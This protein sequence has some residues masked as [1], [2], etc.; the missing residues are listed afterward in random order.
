MDPSRKTCSSVV[1]SSVATVIPEPVK[2]FSKKHL[3]PVCQKVAV[4]TRQYILPSTASY[5]KTKVLPFSDPPGWAGKKALNDREIEHL[6]AVISYSQKQLESLD[7]HSE[8]NIVPIH[9]R[10]SR[11][12]KA[13]KKKS[14]KENER[15]QLEKVIQKFEERLELAK[16][17]R[18]HLNARWNSEILSRLAGYVGG[19]T[20]AVIGSSPLIPTGLSLIENLV[21]KDLTNLIKDVDPANFIPSPTTFAISQC[22]QVL[23]IGMHLKGAHRLQNARLK[24]ISVTEAR[25]RILC[26]IAAMIYLFA[27]RQIYLSTCTDSSTDLICKIL[28]GRNPNVSDNSTS[29]D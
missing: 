5:V 14:L 15:T 24:K 29:I 28:P 7:G 12:V 27:M 22:I 19:I 8:A 18:S 10:K 17:Y 16:A 6:T 3:G 13:Y 1:A 4:F 20:A 9:L 11:K 23:A 26:S 21:S 25:N 2:R